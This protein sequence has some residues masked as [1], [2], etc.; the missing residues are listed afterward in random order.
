MENKL[1]LIVEDNFL[2]YDIIVEQQNPNKPRNLKIRGPYIV[3]GK[4]NQN[5]RSYEEGPME[6]TVNDYQNLITNNRSVGELNHP[7]SVSV[8]YE[9]GCHKVTSLVKDGNIWIGESNVLKGL[10]K[11]D[12]LFHLL[13]NNVKVG[14]STRGVGKTDNYG[15]VTKYKLIAIDAVSDPSADEAWVDGI[16]E[17]KDYMINNYGDVVE[18]AYD[19]LNKNLSHIPNTSTEKDEYIVE[20]LKNFLK[21]I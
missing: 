19:I 20:C 1:K 21:S 5:E 13:E 4:K 10:P 9:R 16:L 6:E 8:D 11:G 7:K 12:I 18:V 15:K 14:M 2:D 3:T 17:S